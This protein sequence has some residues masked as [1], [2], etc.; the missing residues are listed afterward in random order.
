MHDKAD[1]WPGGSPGGPVPVVDAA[2]LKSVWNIYQQIESQHPGGNVA[3]CTTLIEQACSAGADIRAVAY[4]CRM[5]QILERWRGEMLASLKQ[6]GQ[7]HEAV[8]K[9]AENIP[10]RW[11]A[12][13]V[14]AIAC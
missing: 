13:G 14:S 12:R 4:R 8:F 3:V 2:D 10:M 5:L 6:N 1:F 9:V 7:F 11:I